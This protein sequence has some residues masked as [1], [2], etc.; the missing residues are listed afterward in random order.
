ML[1]KET[2]TVHSESY[3]SFTKVVLHQR[4]ALITNCTL[5]IYPQFEMHTKLDEMTKTY[6]GTLFILIKRLHI[7]VLDGKKIQVG[8]SLV[9]PS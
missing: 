6:K 9:I 8:T 1:D 5:P 7:S 3:D 2:M 4:S